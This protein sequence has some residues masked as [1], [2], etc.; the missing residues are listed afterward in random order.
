[1]QVSRACKG[2]LTASVRHLSSVVYYK[3]GCCLETVKF[4]GCTHERPQ[5]SRDLF[6]AKT[7]AKW[8]YCNIGCHVL[9][10]TQHKIWRCRCIMLE[11]YIFRQTLR[12]F[13]QRQTAAL[14]WRFSFRV[15][16]FAQD[17]LQPLVNRISIKTL[18]R[19]WPSYILSYSSKLN[20]LTRNKR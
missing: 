2:L 20:D 7:L 18:Q 17:C 1:L 19:Y 12:S 10:N 8:L 3:K 5:Y 6:R 9:R 11:S 4:N 13:F 14:L 16:S 15:S